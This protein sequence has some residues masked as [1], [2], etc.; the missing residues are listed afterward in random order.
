[1]TPTL[2][3]LSCAAALSTLAAFSLPA[4]AQSAGS[5]VVQVGWF[6]F[7]PND[8]SDPLQVGGAAIPGSGA[9]IKDADTVGFALTHFFTDNFGVTAD[10]GV[11]PKF[12]LNGAGTLSSLGEVGSAKQWSPAIVAKY[13]FGDAESKFRPFIGAG[14]TYVWYSDVQLSRSL[15]SALTAGTGTA[16]A[17]LSSSWAP[18]ANI[19]AAYNFDKNWSVALSV[20]YIPLKT[21]ADIT[22]TTPAGTVK[23]K[24]SL[25]INPLV[26]F[27]SVGYRF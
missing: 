11:P 13:Y 10:L 9:T 4:A 15:Q 22:G 23:A 27:L 1:M 5:N 7:S 17:D 18:V 21:D 24:T 25:T 2:K 12:K 6:H 14:V 20:S 19:G 16:T 26:T 8:S 3:A